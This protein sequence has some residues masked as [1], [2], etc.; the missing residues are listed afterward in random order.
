VAKT[1]A[2]A[3]VLILASA[4]GS[5]LASERGGQESCRIGEPAADHSRRPMHLS[6]PMEITFIVSLIIAIL[7][8]LI[9]ANVITN[10][11]QSIAV[12]WI[13][14]VAYAILALG[15]LLKGL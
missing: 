12:V 5:R 2:E 8:F 1:H 3:G 4:V 9:A 14:L 10:P 6:R 13:A 11:L 7:A 15:V